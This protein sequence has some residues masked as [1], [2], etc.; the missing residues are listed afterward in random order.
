MAALLT[1]DEVQQVFEAMA[2]RGDEIAFGNLTEGC[3]CRAQLMI[4]HLGAMGVEPGRA[5]ALA[6]DRPLNH[7]AQFSCTWQNAGNAWL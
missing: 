4:E 3:E 5:W 1:P 2:A 6:V 7:R